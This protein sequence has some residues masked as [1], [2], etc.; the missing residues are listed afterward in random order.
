MKVL[1]QFFIPF[2]WIGKRP[3]NNIS[4]D[5]LT[6]CV[7]IT[8]NDVNVMNRKHVN[9]TMICI[10]NKLN[11]LNLWWEPLLAQTVPL[12]VPLVPFP[13]Y[14]CCQWCQCCCVN[15]DQTKQ[16]WFW[17]SFALT[18]ICCQCFSSA[19]SLKFLFHTITFPKFFCQYLKIKNNITFIVIMSITMLC[20]IRHTL[21]K[22]FGVNEITDDK[23]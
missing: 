4:P 10:L 2:W 11:P 20:Y 19:F 7:N 21:F 13:N 1:E 12:V 23:R 17:L 5:S 22:D 15:I 18:Y 16:N 9:L 14:R 3:P 6:L 8:V